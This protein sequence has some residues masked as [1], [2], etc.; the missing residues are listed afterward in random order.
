MKILTLLP[1]AF[2]LA[3]PAGPA[4]AEAAIRSEVVHFQKGKT[5]ATVKGTITGREVADYRV[6]AVAGQIMDVSLKWNRETAYYNVLPPGEETALFNGSIGGERFS[7]ALPKS[8]EYI[9]RVYLM[10]D[11]R[12]S[13]KTAQYTLDIDI[14]DRPVSAA[15]GSQPPVKYDASGRIRCSEGRDTLDREC[16]FRVVRNLSAKSAQIWIGHTP[17]GRTR[18][19]HYAERRFTTDDGAAVAAKRENDNWRLGIG[20][21]EFYLIPDAVMQGG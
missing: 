18:V 5:G 10:G 20:N 2:A 7:G 21:R 9:I 14:S 11:A 16:D 4:R 13:G 3:L 12:S 15:A 19:L 8:G 6:R 17:G 1:L